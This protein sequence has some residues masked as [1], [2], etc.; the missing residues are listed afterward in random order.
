PAK[1]LALVEGSGS[2]GGSDAQGSHRRCSVCASFVA[3]DPAR[4]PACNC[5]AWRKREFQQCDS[6][7]CPASHLHSTD[8]QNNF[9]RIGNELPPHVLRRLTPGGVPPSPQ[10]LTHPANRPWPF[11]C[12]GL[13]FWWEGCV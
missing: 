3:I 10:P 8:P 11:G 5:L 13:L 1:M 2:P 7:P 12:R 4:E 9:W 6:A